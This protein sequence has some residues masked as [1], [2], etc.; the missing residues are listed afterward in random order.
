MLVRFSST[1]TESILMFE[2]SASRLIRMMGASGRIPGALYPADVP[3][4][5]E[6]LRSG[7]ANLPVSEAAADHGAEARG[8]DGGEDDDD[9]GYSVSLEMRAAPLIDLLERAAEHEAEVMWS[10]DS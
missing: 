10:Y 3:A 9:R 8:R 7:L 5:I 2:D 4:A 1:A 6:R